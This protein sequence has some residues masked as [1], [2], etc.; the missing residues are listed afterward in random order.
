MIITEKIYCMHECLPASV[1]VYHMNACWLSRPEKG[2]VDGYELP[3]GCWEPH[4]GPLE[5]Q[6]VLLMLPSSLQPPRLLYLWEVTSDIGPGSC[7]V[8]GWW[9]LFTHGCASQHYWDGIFT[10]QPQGPGCGVVFMSPKKQV[11]LYLMD[12]R[13]AHIRIWKFWTFKKQHEIN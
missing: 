12:G 13:V 3:C 1:S 6:Q 2:V 11:L 7:V 5:M 9:L 10:Y 8:G 4:L